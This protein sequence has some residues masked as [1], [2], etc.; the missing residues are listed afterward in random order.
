MKCLFCVYEQ[1]SATTI[2]LQNECAKTG[3][4][5]KTIPSTSSV[6]PSVSVS[7]SASIP[8]S[9]PSLLAGVTSFSTLGTQHYLHPTTH[10]NVSLFFC[11]TPYF[12][13]MAACTILHDC[14]AP[15]Q[16]DDT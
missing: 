15:L 14:S 5:P 13:N 16:Q 3:R 12:Y 1:P 11:S 7:P 6:L 4:P 9:L 10:F 8:S 2:L